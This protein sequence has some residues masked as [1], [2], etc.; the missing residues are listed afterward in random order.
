VCLDCFILT[1]SHIEFVF[2]YVGPLIIVTLII[3]SKPVNVITFFLVEDIVIIF[4]DETS[5]SMGK[6]ADF[7]VIIV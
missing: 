5:Q 4:G 3:T 6:L 7:N 1:L 2:Y